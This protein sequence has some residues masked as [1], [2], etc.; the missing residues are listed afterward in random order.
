MPSSPSSSSRLVSVSSWRSIAILLLLQQCLVFSPHSTT[1][2]HAKP[3]E[4]VFISTGHL[5]SHGETR[6][7]QRHANV[8]GT[9]PSKSLAIHTA[10][11]AAMALNSISFM[12]M[13]VGMKNSVEVKM[14]TQ[15]VQEG[16]TRRSCSVDDDDDDDRLY[17]GN[18]SAVTKRGMESRVVSWNFFQR[19]FSISNNNHDD[20]NGEDGIVN[21]MMDKAQ[22][23]QQHRQ[24]CTSTTPS[25]KRWI[26]N[27]SP[28]PSHETVAEYIGRLWFLSH[29]SNTNGIKFRETIKVVS[30]SRDGTLATVEC[31]TEYYNGSTWVSC[32]KII[33]EF[34][35]SGRGGEEEGGGGGGGVDVGVKMTLDC[36][37][38]VWL[39]LPGSAS[40][41]VRR[42]IRS[43]FES[44]AVDF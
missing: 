3:T 38:L 13:L 19:F 32:C 18:G 23:Q 5:P 25:S 21:T 39:P 9:I 33:C 34:V 26:S 20:G 43:V 42:K 40:R 44:V 31:H 12:E 7:R 14:F 4:P 10:M 8:K 11:D 36:E 22:Q 17:G 28:C 29:N 2:I 16:T 27:P 30:L 6:Q 41:A 1:Y 37:L 35:S 15:S 24:D